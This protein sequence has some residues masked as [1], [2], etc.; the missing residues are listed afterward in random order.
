MHVSGRVGSLFP[1]LLEHFLNGFKSLRGNPQE[2]MVFPMK[3]MGFPV[4]FQLHSRG[5]EPP[6]R[7]VLAPGKLKQLDEGKNMG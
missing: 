3:I 7:E 5:A 2:I 1:E 6:V 4:D